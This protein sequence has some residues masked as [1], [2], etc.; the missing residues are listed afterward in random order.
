MSRFHAL[1]LVCVIVIAG[2]FCRKSAAAD[3]QVIPADISRLVEEAIQRK[4]VLSSEHFKVFDNLS[5]PTQHEVEL[6]VEFGGETIISLWVA[7]TQGPFA[8]ELLDSNRQSVLDPVC[9][10]SFG[11]RSLA[12]I[13]SLRS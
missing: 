4:S 5:S 12:L 2:G 13:C 1:L 10:R 6:N 3:P 11:I 9:A 8:M 7:T